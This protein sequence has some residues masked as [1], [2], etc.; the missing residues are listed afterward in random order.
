MDT[1]GGGGKRDGHSY[2][3]YDEETGIAVFASPT[4]RPGEHFLYF[5]PIDCLAPDIRQR[6][7]DSEE[8]QSMMEEALARAG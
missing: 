5:D 1:L 7:E 4:V 8:R 3:H 2:E 6:W